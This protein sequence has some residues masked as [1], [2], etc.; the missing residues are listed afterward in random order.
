MTPFEL[1]EQYIQL[2]TKFKTESWVEFAT[3]VN[4][5]V[6]TPLIFIF[7]LLTQRAT[8]L[9]ILTTCL[10]LFKLFREYYRY[11]VLRYKIQQ[12]YIL[13]MASGGP[14]ITT[15][16]MDYMPYVFADAVVR[17]CGHHPHPEEDHQPWMRKECNRLIHENHFQ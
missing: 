4:D 1:A 10:E 5:L 3:H 9:F 7:M 12:M 11:S 13:T 14:H 15:N 16:N 2:R 17:L 8:P 6:L